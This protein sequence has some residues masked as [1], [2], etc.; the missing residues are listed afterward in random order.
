MSETLIN[1]LSHR[2]ETATTVNERID[3][4]SELKVTLVEI[5]Q[6]TNLDIVS[7]GCSHCGEVNFAKNN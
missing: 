5:S 7:D 2:L 3:T 4:L 6:F 1:Q